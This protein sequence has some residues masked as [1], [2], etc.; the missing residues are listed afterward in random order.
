MLGILFPDNP[1]NSVVKALDQMESDLGSCTFFYMFPIILTDNGSEFMNP[2]LI[3]TG[4]GGLKER[5]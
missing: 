4:I 2:N 5:R 1:Q 3:E